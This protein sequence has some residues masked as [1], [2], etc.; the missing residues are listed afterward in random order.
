MTGTGKYRGVVYCRT[1]K[2]TGQC[3]IGET[4]NEKVRKQCWN[5][6]GAKNN[7]AGEKI[8]RTREEY[9]IDSRA[10]D[11]EVLDEVICENLDELHQ[12]LHD[13]QAHWIREKNSVEKGFNGSYGDGMEG[14]THTPESR[15]LISKNHRNYQTEDTKIKL[16]QLMKGRTISQETREKI[17]AG[18]K[19]KKRT[20][21]QRRAESE[22]L[23]GKVPQ[24]ATDGAKRWVKK[25]GGGYWKGKNIPAA[26]RANMKAAQQK[27]GIKVVAIGPT[28]ERQE[29]PTMLDAAKGTVHNVG[30]VANAVKS[31]GTTMKGYKF[32]RL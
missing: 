32:E 2:A 22:R 31:G 29:Y 12:I 24:A 4:D 8:V 16:S 10:W 30:S 17:S 13:R 26:A 15:A 9:G 19:G 11:Y 3:Y 27:R 21:E 20:P 25:N 28:G 14:R 6:P 5:K 1:L 23:K 7:Y 18:N